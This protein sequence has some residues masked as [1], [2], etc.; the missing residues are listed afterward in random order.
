MK[1]KLG[2]AL[3]CFAFAIPFGGVG[4]GAAYAIVATI[5]D[6]MAAREWVRVKAEVLDYGSGRVLYRYRMDGQSYTGDR[7]GSNVL[8]G[9]D[10]VDSWHEDIEAML[11]AAKS[12]GKPITV[13][14]NP[15]NP[16]ESMVDREIRWKLLVFF[17]PFALAFGGVGV[18]ALAMMVRGWV[19]GA[20]ANLQQRKSGSGLRGNEKIPSDQ[21]SGMLMLWVFTFFWNAI[22]LPIAILFI[23]EAIRNGEWLALLVGI[24]PLVG[25]LMIWGCIA[26]T[27]NYLR[28]GG[29]SLQ[30]DDDKPRVGGAVAGHVAF[31]RGITAGQAFRVKLVCNRGTS[32]DDGTSWGQFW[33]KQVE[34]RT[35]SVGGNVRLPF[36][37]ETPGNLP[38]TTDTNDARG[39]YAWRVEVTPVSSASAV[40]YGFD[41]T[42]RPAAM[43]AQPAMAFADDALPATLGPGFEGVEQMLG[44]A[45]VSL[46]QDQARKLRE[47][48]PEQRAAVKKLVE[49]GPTIKKWV[50]GIVIAFVVIQF[51]MGIVPFFV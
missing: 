17:S 40:P 6:G 26:G 20:P 33:A 25:A 49:H 13:F 16:A 38:A 42:M 28:R 5:R 46:T 14:V 23:P 41:V 7:L 39:R 9:T 37:F 15:D 48:T 29:A 47:L 32:D 24:F 44:G 4:A 12:E 43:A 50:I 18:G 22:S 35:T 11:A 21:R 8:G 30:L 36:R 51:L 31:P 27:I 2:A 34:A 45:G 19:N 3:M 10:N 1:E